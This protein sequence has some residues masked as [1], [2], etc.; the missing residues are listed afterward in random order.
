[1][2]PGF[3]TYRQRIAQIANAI[4][5]RGA[6]PVFLS[7]PVLWSEGLSPAAEKL[8]WLGYLNANRFLAAPP[9]RQCMDRYNDCLRDV[10]QEQQAPWIDLSDMSGRLVYFY[11]DCHFTE[12]GAREVA[13][14]VAAGL[15]R[16]PVE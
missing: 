13:R 12:A 15:P 8:L 11:D 16:S 6:T 9:L 1:L 7:Q 2:Q 3:E 14:I 10:C 4:R 5:Q